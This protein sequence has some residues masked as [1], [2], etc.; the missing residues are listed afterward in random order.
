MYE[1]CVVKAWPTHNIWLR[2]NMSATHVWPCH[3]KASHGPTATE[4]WLCFVKAQATV[5]HPAFL[6]RSL[7][8]GLLCLMQ[9]GSQYHDIETSL[10][11]AEYVTRVGGASTLPQGSR[12]QQQKISLYVGLYKYTS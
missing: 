12:C 7:P 10:H 8:D 2:L 3:A 9:F 11:A 1:Q 6:P 4:L 5:L